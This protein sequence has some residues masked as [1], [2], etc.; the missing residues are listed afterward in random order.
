MFE[1]VWNAIEFLVV[2]VIFKMIIGHAIADWL[3]ARWK[4]FVGKTQNYQTIWQHY[5]NRAN[6]RGHDLESVLD[7]GQDTCG[8]VYSR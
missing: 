5:Y 8:L 7:C 6:G 1:L 3:L 2:T 4:T